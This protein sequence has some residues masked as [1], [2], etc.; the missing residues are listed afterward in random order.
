MAA[1]SCNAD[2]VIVCPYFQACYESC[3][4]VCHEIPDP[5]PGCA[6]TGACFAFDGRK[7]AVSTVAKAVT[8]CKNAAAGRH[9]AQ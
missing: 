4:I 3:T 6:Y 7:S 5:P 8:R 2:C 9:Q 1:M